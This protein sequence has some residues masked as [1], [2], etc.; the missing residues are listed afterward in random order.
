MSVESPLPTESPAVDATGAATDVAAVIPDPLPANIV[1]Y[2]GVCN[3]C[4][5][6]VRFAVDRD[7]EGR[8]HYASLQSK[9]GHALME[10]VGL[11][12]GRYDTFVFVEDGVAHVRSTAAL[13]LAKKLRGPWPAMS[14]FLIVPRP[15]RDFVYRLVSKSR[16]LWFGRTDACRIPTPDERERFLDRD[17]QL[18]DPP[19]AG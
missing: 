5:G 18:N 16:Y 9:L 8:I 12:S 3:L 10:H 4:T 13:R 14:V 15:I 1:L 2:D 6:T 11:P 7:P 19:S 17:E